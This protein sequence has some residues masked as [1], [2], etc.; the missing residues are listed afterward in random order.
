MILFLLLQIDVDWMEIVGGDTLLMD[1]TNW[2]GW[3]GAILMESNL[4]WME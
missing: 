4:N 3:D 2:C 1:S